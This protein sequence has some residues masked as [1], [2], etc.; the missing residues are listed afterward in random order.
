MKSHELLQEVFK[1]ACIKNIAKELKLS[2]V[3]VHK[4]TESTDVNGSG[5]LNPLDRVDD[6]IRITGD[7]RIAQWVCAQAGGYFVHN[8]E[9]K[10]G[11]ARPLSAAENKVVHELAEIISS[12]SASVK[13]GCI[14]KVESQKIRSRWEELKSV[15]EGFVRSCESGSFQAGAVVCTR[16][17]A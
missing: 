7:R 14:S 12:I 5:E 17:V 6:L 10:N 15:T 1:P 11:K 4:W 16:L 8:P 3:L 2:R 9:T 13:D